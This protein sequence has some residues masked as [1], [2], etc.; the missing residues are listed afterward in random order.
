MEPD[1]TVADQAALTSG[2]DFWHTTPAAGLPSITVTDGPHGV[3][4][5][6]SEHDVVTGRPATCFPPAVATASTWDPD[7]L[8]RMGEALGDECRAM[9]VAVLLGPGIN[10]KRTPL[11]GRNFEYFA[12]DP[13]LTGVLATEWVR[14]LQSRGVGASLKHFAVNSQE[15]DR[16]RIS[17]DVDERTLRE[18]Y[19][20]AFQR[21]VTQ[22]R[23]WTV[24]CS[25]NRIN[26]VHASQNR[27]LL[28]EVLRDEWGFEGVVVSDW[29][30][31]A[32]RVAAVAAGL[33]LTM[34]G[35]D[36]TGDRALAEAVADGR[37]DPAA[38]RTAAD[39]VRALVERAGEREPAGYDADAH[40]ALAREI[41]GRAI[42]L[43][44]NEG[45]VL[46]LRAGQSLA[47]LG[48]FARTP[49]YQ[50]GGSSQITPTRLD[51]A[52]TALAGSAPVRFAPGYDDVDEAVALA[53]DSDVALV[54]VGSEHET[55]GADR[56]S[57]DLPATHR[58]LIERVAAVNPRTVVVLSNGTV[59]LTR[60][61]E[62]AVPAIVEGWLL[63]QAGGSAI[64]DVLFGRVNPSGRLAETIPVRLADHPSFLDF[65]G[66]NGHVRYGEGIHV[67]YRGFDARELEVAYPFGF[68]L[69][70]T[71]FEYGEAR[72]TAT[73]A[74]IE[75]RVPVTN[76]GDRD[77]REVVQVYVSVPGSRV[78]RAPRELKAFA[79]VPIAA[80][81]TAEVVL[82]IAREDLAYWDTRLHR[83]I[84]EGGEYHCAV[85]SSS[86]DLH[87]TAMAEVTG[88][89]VRVPL[90]GEST[91]AEWFADPRGAE[92]LGQAFAAAAGSGPI[93]RLVADPATIS[94]VGSLPLS[95]MS[96]FP[97]SPLTAEALAKLI[98][99]VN[100]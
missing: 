32:D 91:V 69:S 41:A 71:T 88:D 15:T 65:P 8:R 47:V 81:E 78:R 43:L 85:G 38:L 77:G 11:G 62:A 3:R 61:W 67:G 44:K 19:L 75:V 96:A 80:G 90:T 84:V 12:E 50:G 94:L 55:E 16:M 23:P 99:E 21:V 30:A 45:G 76:T 26:G 1:P 73:D 92:L 66:E 63:G 82:H 33:D 49:R 52:L 51:G 4:L 25:Y 13:L 53:A 31:V 40:H 35:P 48:E 59:V 79:S 58:E 83:W 17:A 74:G 36:D 60:P 10:L 37:L 68:G 56:E 34:P 22:A 89:D 72:A 100:G 18:M 86:R 87:T 46:P 2:N 97:G 28:T 98:A 57:L 54:F 64:A 29:G 7:L 5:Q 20:R 42:V 95:R 6:A 70:Y 24:M 93:G 27:W 39:R 14:G 9:D